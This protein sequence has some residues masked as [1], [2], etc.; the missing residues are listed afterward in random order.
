MDQDRSLCRFCL[1]SKN[2]SANPLISPCNCKGS[3]EFVHLKCLNR[4]RRVDLQR[5]GRMCGLCLTNYIHLQPIQ[6]EVIPETTTIVLYCLDYPGLLLLFYNYIYS[7]VLSSTHN[8]DYEFLQTYYIFSQYVFHC[9]YAYFFYS[10]WNVA[11]K[12]LYWHQIKTVWTPVVVGTHIYMFVLLQ[13]SAFLLGPF[14]SFYMGLYWV[15]H[16][17][18]LR[19]MNNQ[20]AQMD[21]Y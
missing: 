20:I 7:I 1:S 13:E 6:F 9:V 18:L 19:R 3:L 15:L 5:N 2:V 17:R 11:N 14:L 21:H 16:K 8:P 12:E 10:E 4:W